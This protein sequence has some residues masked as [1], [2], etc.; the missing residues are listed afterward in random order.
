MA[1]H[2]ARE[3]DKE[4]LQVYF[5]EE[6]KELEAHSAP[7]PEAFEIGTSGV[8]YHTVCREWRFRFTGRDVPFPASPRS[9]ERGTKLCARRRANRA[10][11]TSTRC[12]P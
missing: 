1:A 11:C 2:K 7:D 6:M 4:N 10:S 3:D 5:G 12:G 9:N 8:E